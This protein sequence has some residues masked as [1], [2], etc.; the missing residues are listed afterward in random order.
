VPNDVLQAFVIFAA[1]LTKNNN[2]NVIIRS[3][4]RFHL[5]ILPTNPLTKIHGRPTYDTLNELRNELKSN[6]SSIPTSRGG[7]GHGYLGLILSADDYNNAVGQ[8]FNLPVAPPL[9]PNI[10]PVP[11]PPKSQKPTAS[12]PKTFANGENTTTFKPPFEN[13]FS[14]P[15]KMSTFPP[16]RVRSPATTTSPSTTF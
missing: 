15:S 4:R 8:P 16:S 2:K 14:T 9:Q 12:M 11:P 1:E 5:G 7:G 3:D 13:N 10:L 6:A